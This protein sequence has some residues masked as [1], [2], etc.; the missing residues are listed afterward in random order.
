MSGSAVL[1][2]GGTSESVEIFWP[3][4]LSASWTNRANSPA[5]MLVETIAELASAMSA[6]LRDGG[7]RA[8]LLE[9]RAHHALLPRHPRVVVGVVA[10]PGEPERVVA[11][12]LAD[13]GL[14]VAGDVGAEA[15]DRD[16]LAHVEGDAADRVDEVAEALEVDHRPV[17]DLQPGDALDRHDR[18]VDAGVVGV[19]GTA[20]CCRRPRC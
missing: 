18:G 3:R 6:K 15:A 9:H 1:I 2:I 20:R 17:V 14:D 7:L 12:E 5:G 16:R 10:G 11:V 13:A 4:A 19:A 8:D